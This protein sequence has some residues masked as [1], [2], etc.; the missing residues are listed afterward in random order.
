VCVEKGFP[1]KN[2]RADILGLA[3]A[4]AIDMTSHG[5]H[6]QRKNESKRKE[7]RREALLDSVGFI[8]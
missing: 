7:P 6:S 3:I 2:G 4:I 8:D 1:V 5:D